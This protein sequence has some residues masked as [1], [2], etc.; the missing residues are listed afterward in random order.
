MTITPVLAEA[1]LTD[2]DIQLKVVWLLGFCLE[3]V[4]YG[5]YVCL[6]M[7][8]LPVLIRG[9]KN[10]SATIFLIG[11]VLIFVVASIESGASLCRALVAF[12]YQTDV[13]DPTRIYSNMKYW[14]NY[15]PWVLAIIPFTTGDILM[16]CRCFI[17]WQRSYWVILLPATLAAVSAG[18][19]I[20]TVWYARQG[21]LSLHLFQNRRLAVLTTV[22]SLSQTIL[23]TSLIVWKIL[24]RQRTAIQ[25]ASV[26]TPCLVSI[27]RIIMESAA[28]YTVGMLVMLILIHLDHPAKEMLHVCTVAD[29]QSLQYRFL[30]IR[31]LESLAFW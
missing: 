18:F 23:T 14:A 24:S 7:A 10:F 30:T 13:R 27:A 26:H 29:N 12:G 22:F 31:S 19:H 16:I 17:I 8:A 2:T 25:L 9:N 28:I 20:A 5:V 4:L 6:F 15:L 1:G 3:C 11:N 21:T